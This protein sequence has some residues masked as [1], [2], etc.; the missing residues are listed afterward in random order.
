MNQ[1][2]LKDSLSAD[3]RNAVR[4]EVRNLLERSDAFARLEPAQKQCL[5]QDLVRVVSYMADPAAGHPELRTLGERVRR[6]PDE[7]GASATALASKATPRRRSGDERPPR[8]QTTGEGFVGG[9]AREGTE[10]FTRLVNEVDFPAFVSGLVEGVFTSIVNS[11]IRQMEAYQKLLEAVVTSV[12]DF[13]DANI[14]EESARDDLTR[15][16]PKALRREGTGS[17]SRL[18]LNPDLD[19]AQLPNFKADLGLDFEPDFDDEE[20]EKQVVEAGRLKMARLKQQQLATMVLM[21]INRIIVTDGKINAKVTFDFKSEDTAKDQRTASSERDIDSEAKFSSSSGGGWGSSGDS[22]SNVKTTVSSSFNAQSNQE[23]ESKLEMK[24][25]L[26][27]EV[28]INFRSETF[29]LDRINPADMSLV[30]ERAG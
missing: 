6:T 18:R 8:R 16:Y 23:S 13:A 10:Q 17:Q 1:H 11:S 19:E 4:W 3:E 26:S 2:E 20:V 7:L 27:G 21:G 15:K 30:Q 12:K 5:A 29:P 24:A 25:K 22:R 14:S 28:T 9:A